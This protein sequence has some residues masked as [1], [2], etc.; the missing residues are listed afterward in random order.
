MYYVNAT[1]VNAFYTFI[2]LLIDWAG[3]VVT[4]VPQTPSA[5]EIFDMVF[6]GSVFAMCCA[7]LDGASLYIGIKMCY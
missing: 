1:S 5:I 4:H 3:A 6:N 7:A 2:F